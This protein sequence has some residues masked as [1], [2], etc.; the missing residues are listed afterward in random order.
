MKVIDL[1][2]AAR[3]RW[4][5]IFVFFF[6]AESFVFVLG[7]G[8][9][10]A[11]NH[12]D[13]IYYSSAKF[14][15]RPSTLQFSAFGGK[16]GSNPTRNQITDT[17]FQDFDSVRAILLEKSFLEKI[18][19]RM[20]K[21]NAPVTPEELRIRVFAYPSAINISDAANFL[22]LESTPDNQDE[23]EDFE[24]SQEELRKRRALQ[25][26]NLTISGP[27]PESSQE[28]ARIIVEEFLEEM[29]NRAAKDSISRRVALED[30]AK[31]TQGQILRLKNALKKSHGKLSAAELLDLQESFQD[32]VQRL[33][34]ARAQLLASIH[35]P[36]P[37]VGN[38]NPGSVV[39]PRLATARLDVAAGSRIYQTDSQNLRPYVEHL[40]AME[41]LR[42]RLGQDFERARQV[43]NN[44]IRRSK[45]QEAGR[46]ANEIEKLES[47]LGGREEMKDI[48]KL[49]FALHHWEENYL[50]LIPQLFRA[51]LEER[52]ALEQGSLVLTQKPLPG[53]VSAAV[54]E[55]T[56][57]LVATL[58]F[59]PIVSCF[60]VVLA[61]FLDYFH[62]SRAV[63]SQLESLGIPILG[64]IYTFPREESQPWKD[65]RRKVE[66][67]QRD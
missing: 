57:A 34:N 23:L 27:T 51:R 44:S 13:S 67:R 50:A 7:G 4:L 38:A 14:L 16:M 56:Q 49:D 29:K 54:A 65:L 43:Q 59:I 17:W 47:L 1:W 9:A 11:K 15:L 36:E 46:L 8:F 60:S 26:I 3:R 61:L 2:L 30:L 6:V 52:Q 28:L 31:R 64:I 32:E 41:K 58:A 10:P 21:G 62:R 48:V 12:R 66:R 24:K 40:K 5:F 25:M 33:D 42:D 35:A 19:S 22:E 37:L 20:G 63:A 45:E 18:S 53:I 55:S 39:D